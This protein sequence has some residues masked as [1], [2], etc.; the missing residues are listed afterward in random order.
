MIDPIALARQLIDIPSTTDNEAAVGEFLEGALQRL[1]FACR[2]HAVTETRFNLFAAAGGRPRV[3]L[4]SHIDTVPPWFASAEDEEY[5]YGRG[6]CDT[7]GVYAAM[8]AAGERL[9]A[10]GMNEFAFLFVVGEETDSIGAK[11]A[12]TEF[13]ALGSEFVVV[14]EPTESTF[15]RA[16]KGAFTCTVRFDGMAGHSAYPERGDSAITK[17]AAAITEINAAQW[18]R[19]EVLGQATVNV[20]VVRGGVKPNVIAGEAEA[21][22]IFRLVT[23]PEDVRTKLEGII[24]RH[25]GKIIKSGGNPPQFMTVPE[26]EPSRVVAFNTDVP[27]LRNLGKPLLFGPGSILEAHGPNERIAK[28]DLLAA[29]STYEEMVVAL[30]EGRV[31]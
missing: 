14:G 28:K 15:A 10:R 1:G 2:R 3:I 18:G 16:S 29:V 17:L 13:A 6:A 27:H 31:A 7:K 11:T 20:G 30:L 19:N 8:I 22:M 5:L 23:D 24:S 9:V 12:N 4:N 26:G 21:E 25:G